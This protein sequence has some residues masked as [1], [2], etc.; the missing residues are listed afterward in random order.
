MNIK[1]IISAILSRIKKLETTAIS[2]AAGIGDGS[3]SNTEFQYLNGVTSAIQTQFSGKKD[4]T[5][6]V[7]R[8]VAIMTQASTNAPTATVLENSLG[9]TVV[10]TYGGAGTYIATL[11]GAFT[12]N[13]TIV[14]TSAGIVGGDKYLEWERATADV[15]NIYVFDTAAASPDFGGIF[16]IVIEVYP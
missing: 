13:K 10:W 7:K 2:D 15:V 8:Y 5:A 11:A 4:G 14:F 12:E 6:G 16:S 1:S 9:G 3:V